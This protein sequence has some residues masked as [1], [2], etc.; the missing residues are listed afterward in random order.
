MSDQGQEYWLAQRQVELICARRDAIDAQKRLLAARVAVK[1]VNPSASPH[2]RA[3]TAEPDDL[4]TVGTPDADAS[5]W[6]TLE[7]LW[8]G[9]VAMLLLFNFAPHVFGN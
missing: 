7:N 9:V 4:A 1:S 2:N 3:G 6:G 8:L 5:R